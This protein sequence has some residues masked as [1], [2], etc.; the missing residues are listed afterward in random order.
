MKITL[1]SK[2]LNKK[3]QLL[4]GVINNSNAMPV[5]DNF[6]FEIDEKELKITATDLE[7]TMSTT[8]VI[9]SQGKAS[10][11]IES[12][13]LTEALKTFADQPLVFTINENNT[14]EIS[15]EN[16]KYEIAYLQS[17]EFPKAP[18]L[19]KTKSIVIPSKA[20]A[21]GINKTL[22]AVGNDDMRIVMTGVLF[23]LSAEGLN[24]VSTDANRLV[25]YSFASL[26]SSYPIDMIVPKK[27]LGILKSVL[28]TAEQDVILNFNQ[29]NV[30]FEFS[31]YSVQ[32]RLIDG[33]YPNYEGVIPKDNP[34]KVVIDRN[35]FLQSVKRINT[36]S[37]KQTHQ[38]KLK[39][40]GAELNITAEDIDYSN[41]ADEKLVC[42][43]EGNDIEIG[44]N[45]KFLI[46]ILSNLD[47]KDV[48][49]E[50]SNPMRAGIITP[51]DGLEEGEN[52]LMLVMPVKI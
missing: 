14:I 37:N 52:L 4:S 39:I 13:I 18:E 25:K 10:V 34:N 26:K 29:T 41:K 5:L 3:L 28:G 12:K 11:L 40:I 15:S 30:S 7:T 23:Q 2:E 16:G 51:V 33:K 24:F 38:I 35:S 43:Y 42:N 20:L 32:V 46:D 19:E 48:Q 9:D 1:N 31:D 44:F 45:S 27:P 22:F 17:D 36:F 50:M 21:K 8:M 49:L 6:L 47:S